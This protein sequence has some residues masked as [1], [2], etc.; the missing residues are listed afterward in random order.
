M[1]TCN[2]Q[3][4]LVKSTTFP[5]FP[6]LGLGSDEGTPLVNLKLHLR[7]VGGTPC[8]FRE[9]HIGKAASSGPFR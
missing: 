7:S 9:R 3:F 5:T 8:P 6:E 1:N 4:L 2:A